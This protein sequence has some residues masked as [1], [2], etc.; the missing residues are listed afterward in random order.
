MKKIFFYTLVAIL[1]CSCGATQQDYVNWGDGFMQRGEHGKA[2]EYYK[3]AAIIYEKNNNLSN[4]IHF[5]DLAG[6]TA[7]TIELSSQYAAYFENKRDYKNAARYYQKAKNTTKANEMYLR[8]AQDYESK[9]DYKGAL[10]CY[11]KLGDTA[12]INEM[13]LKLAQDYESKHK[14]QEAILYYEKLGNTAKVNEM[15]LKLAQSYESKKKYQKAL[16]YYQKLGNIT[17]IDEIYLLMAQK[18]FAN[19]DIDSV[20]NALDICK[21]ITSDKMYKQCISKGALKQAENCNNG[22]KLSCSNAGALYNYHLND[23]QKSLYYHHIGYDKDDNHNLDSFVQVLEKGCAKGGK[24]DCFR[25]GWI[26]SNEDGYINYSKAI[27]VYTKACNLNHYTACN[28]LGVL[29]QKSYAV[30]LLDNKKSLELYTKA[31]KGGEMI[32]CSNIG[33]MYEQGKAV[34]RNYNTAKS[35]YKKACNGGYEKACGFYNNLEE[36]II[37]VDSSDGFHILR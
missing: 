31:C 32:A 12:K 14:N 17:K 35:Y 3:K 28:N 33:G 37:N 10:L 25:L 34:K 24:G 2:K 5:Y 20:N 9:Q 16:T 11:E 1:L 7:K 4:A 19:S 30:K 18:S 8:L 29:Y 21:N 6:D 27:Q 26:R 22:D 36:N 23:I 15:Y 13:Y